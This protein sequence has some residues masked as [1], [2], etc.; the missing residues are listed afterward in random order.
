MKSALV[1]GSSRGIGRG[2][3][4]ALARQGYG[5]TV[6]SRSAADLKEL[7]SDLLSAGAGEVTHLPADMTDRT[8]LEA[9]VTRHHE[10][11]GSMDT[12]ILN[13]GMGIAGR[14]A[15]FPIELVAKIMEVNFAAALVLLHHSLPL[16]RTAA[17]QPTRCGAK[18]IS[19]ASITGIYPEPG[20][21][22]Y[23]ASKAALISLMENLNAEEGVNGIT[24]TAVAPAFVDTDMTS[25]VRGEIPVQKMIPVDDVVTVI[26]MLLQL[27][28]QTSVTRIVM[29]RSAASG[30]SA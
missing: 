10:T 17:S 27:G 14:I 28:R 12:L 16:L 4:F 11:Y 6:T 29:A 3:A 5:L 30:Y 18:V 21:A 20:L 13:A 1:T 8:T 7:A 26:E 25:W 9:V 23:G 24:A 22:V 15:S 2:I 19:L